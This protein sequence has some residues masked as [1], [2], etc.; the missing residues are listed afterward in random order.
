MSISETKTLDYLFIQTLFEIVK[1]LRRRTTRRD[2][3]LPFLADKWQELIEL[4]WNS[5]DAHVV[6]CE[7]LQMQLIMAVVIAAAAADDATAVAKCAVRTA[8][9]KV[10]V[11]EFYYYEIRGWYD[12]YTRIFYT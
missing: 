8:M 6:V 7:S 9:A 11:V 12:F 4:Q 1:W 5:V 2:H 10:P 3:A